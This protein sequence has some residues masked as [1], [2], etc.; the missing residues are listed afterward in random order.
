VSHWSGLTFQ[1]EV[2]S[3]NQIIYIALDFAIKE[4]VLFGPVSCPPFLENDCFDPS[5]ST[6]ASPACESRL[7]NFHHNV[8][9]EAREDSFK[10]FSHEMRFP[11]VLDQYSLFNHRMYRDVA[12]VLSARQVFAGK[13]IA[14]SPSRGESILQIS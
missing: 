13:V 7:H 12:G 4:T 11:F 9:C 2:G 14:L 1:I 3:Q 6:T 10:V 8:E 5:Q